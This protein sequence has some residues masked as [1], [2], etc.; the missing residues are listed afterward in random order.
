[1]ADFRIDSLQI[2][3]IKIAEKNF[4]E[5][6]KNQKWLEKFF[7][8]SDFLGI[9]SEISHFVL[10]A[11][12]YI[13]FNQYYLVQVIEIDNHGNVVR[14]KLQPETKESNL[15]SSITEKSTLFN[16][17]ETLQHHNLTKSI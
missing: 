10:I 8:C 11:S 1:M 16:V 7:D 17:S 3:K 14:R 13:T 9:K 15:S 2:R 6:L 4:T 12:P 5:V